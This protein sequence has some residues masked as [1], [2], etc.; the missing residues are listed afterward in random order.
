[1]RPLHLYCHN[2]N[3]AT[4]LPAA[5]YKVV[6]AGGAPAPP[7]DYVVI[8]FFVFSNLQNQTKLTQKQN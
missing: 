4:T 5:R 2:L 8:S 6:Q 1:M 7:W 3:Y